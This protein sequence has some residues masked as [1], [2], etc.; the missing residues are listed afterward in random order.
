M[1]QPARNLLVV[2][3]GLQG[4]GKSTA[5]EAAAG[6]LGAAVLSHD[7]AMSGLRPYAEVE[8]ALDSIGLGG[9]RAVGW[10]VLCALAREQL[11]HGRSA[12]LDGMARQADIEKCREL[13]AEEGTRALVILTECADIDVHRSR[14]AGRRQSIPGWYELDWDHVERSR[15]SRETPDGVDLVLQATDPWETNL[16]QLTELLNAV[17]EQ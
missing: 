2:V 6:V 7:W 12:V 14:I 3:T 9:R 8:A 5:A 16:V 11:R 4:T 10:S 15:A 1:N 17:V 13:A